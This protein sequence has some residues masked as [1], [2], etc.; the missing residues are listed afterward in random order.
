MKLS[1]IVQR[2]M[3]PL[4]EAACT[5]KA[6]FPFACL[7]A[8]WCTS[9]IWLPLKLIWWLRHYEIGALIVALGLY[10]AA[11][12]GLPN[13]HLQS[14]QEVWY[15]KGALE[16][17]KDLERKAQED[18]YSW[19][20]FVSPES[21]LFEKSVRYYEDQQSASFLDRL[22]YGRPD[23]ALAA[24]A[25]LKLGVIKMMNSS[26]DPKNMAMAKDLL[27]KAVALNPGIPYAREL[28]ADPSRIDTL[29]L[30][31]LAPERDLE[32]MYQNNPD[33][34]SKHPDKSKDGKKNG[35]GNQQNQQPK[36]GDQKGKGDKPQP[37]PGGKQ[38]GKPNQQQPAPSSMNQML[39]QNLQDVQ[40]GTG[41][42]G[43]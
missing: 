43:I 42:D 23:A 31:A 6:K 34:R 18:Y 2:G 35:Q 13:L 39:Q 17:R 24:Q 26:N 5:C 29:A 8:K 41:N 12:Q 40:N 32:M 4:T 27:E 15:N 1:E 10:A 22:M 19:S 14:P 28:I 30:Q 9:P 21:D 36:P 37:K 16:L 7:I 38:P 25:Y 3:R 11:Y 33:Q 20:A